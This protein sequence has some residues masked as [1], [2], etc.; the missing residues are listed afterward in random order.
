MAGLAGWSCPS[1]SANVA[2][3]RSG[4]A[5][6]PDNW[7]D[8]LTGSARVRTMIDAGAGADEVVAAWQGELAAFRAVRRTYLR[9]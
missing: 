2:G 3:S 4:F 5:W 7:I 6:R 8:K 1:M 9:Y